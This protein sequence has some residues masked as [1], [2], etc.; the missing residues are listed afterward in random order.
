MSHART[1]DRRSA[2][3]S[4]A[5]RTVVFRGADD[6]R[7]QAPQPL[8]FRRSGSVGLLAVL[9]V[10]VGTTALVAMAPHLRYGPQRPVLH[11]QIATAAALV[12][13]LVALLA[14]G[15]YRR[16]PLAADLL[17][18][19]SFAVLGATN[20]LTSAV[21]GLIGH[22]L[23]GPLAWT[24]VSGR[25]VAAALLA[26]AAVSAGRRLARP[27]RAARRLA[28]SSVGALALLALLLAA[29]DPQLLRGVSEGVAPAYGPFAGSPASIALKGTCLALVVVAAV[30]FAL[31]ARRRPDRLSVPLSWGVALLAFA[32]LNGHAGPVALRQLVPTRATCSRSPPTSCS[33]RGPSPRSATTS[34]TARAWRRSRSAGAS[35]ASCTTASRRRSSTCSRRCAACRRSSRDPRRTGC[36]GAAE[37]ALAESRSA[38]STPPALVYE[39]LSATL[40]RIGSELARRFELDVH[41]EADADVTVEPAVRDALARIVG[42]AL[43]NAA[44]HGGA[45]CATIELQAG[46]PARLRVRDDG[47]GFDADPAGVPDGAF[48]LTSIRERA[49]AVGGRAQIR[50]APGDGT[51]IEVTLP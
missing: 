45:R 6:E 29:L 1:F 41:I 7:G 22:S 44:R 16:T 15:R 28:L 42:E 38:I 18:A 10:G 20:L 14:A 23:E 3:A 8:S 36:S 17:L 49:A 46:P 9:A 30:G 11:A 32:W 19:T 24:P 27:S 51:E 2:D 4:A 43:S 37:R 26:G 39:P 12:A 40:A 48:G 21:R 34:R 35:R 31:R 33:P 50:S 47:C 25:V 13:L 5:G